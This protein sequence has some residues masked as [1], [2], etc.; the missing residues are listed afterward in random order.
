MLWLLVV[1]A[2]VV[3]VGLIL[4][5]PFVPTH[6]QSVDKA[7]KML[8]LRR[9]QQLVELGA[10][11]GRIAL[12]AAKKGIKVEAF[13]INPLVFVVCWFRTRSYRRLVKVRLQD[14]KSSA[15]PK[16]TRAIY[17]FGNKFIMNYLSVR[18]QRWPRPI[19]VV[20]YG[21]ELPGS[22][23]SRQSGGLWRYDLEP[24]A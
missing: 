11:D 14:F 16:E 3:G 13:E 5:A 19:R 9:G 22:E 18:L 2:V 10:G 24:K 7:V 23:P 8:G 12:A 6:K 1:L 21:Y 20:S 15:W 17:V 4:G